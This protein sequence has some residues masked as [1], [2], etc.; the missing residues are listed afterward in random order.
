MV[1][2]NFQQNSQNEVGTVRCAVLAA[3]NGATLPPAERASMLAIFHCKITS[4]F[5][6]FPTG[7]NPLAESLKL[8]TQSNRLKFAVFASCVCFASI[9][10]Y[11]RLN[12]RAT[13]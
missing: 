1:P 12:A 10:V 7:Q 6:A 11:S 3:F 4:I 5:S 13:V 8:N 9:R 2:E